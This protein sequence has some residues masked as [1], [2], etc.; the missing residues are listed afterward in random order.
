MA[1]RR[2]HTRR[3]VA[4]ACILTLLAGCGTPGRSATTLTDAERQCADN[5]ETISHSEMR[6]MKAD[7]SIDGIFEWSGGYWVSYDKIMEIC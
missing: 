5:W 6:R 7:R 1:L 4:A 3:L 2:P